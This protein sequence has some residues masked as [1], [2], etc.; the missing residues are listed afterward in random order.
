MAQSVRRKLKR[1]NLR[2]I[3]NHTFK[4]MDFFRR[5]SNGRF[6]LANSNGQD[7][8]QGPGHHVK[9]LDAWQNAV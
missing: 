7:R 5:A 9:T 8:A 3:W 2:M 1:G 6:I 4:R